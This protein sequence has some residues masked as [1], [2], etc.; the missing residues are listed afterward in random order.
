MQ[1]LVVLFI[2]I[3]APCFHI[4]SHYLSLLSS[5][6]L[7]FSS[8]FSPLLLSTLLFPPLL[9]STTLLFSLFPSP[10]IYYSHSLTSS[11]LIYY[12]SLLSFPISSY[13]LLFSSLFSLSAGT[14]KSCYTS[15]GDVCTSLTTL[16]TMC[17][18]QYGG[19]GQGCQ[20][21]N[22]I[23]TLINIALKPGNL[24]LILN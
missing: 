14:S 5:Y 2:I 18:L 1:L 24:K 3:S 15:V 4:F 11:P 6:L 13:L 22:L 19:T 17:P 12:S 7:L 10:L 21:P 9:L 23:T 8:L 16:V 20:P